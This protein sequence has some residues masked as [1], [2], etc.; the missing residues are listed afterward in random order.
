MSMVPK[1]INI[2]KL[3]LTVTTIR[4]DLCRL[5][6]LFLLLALQISMTAQQSPRAEASGSKTAPEKHADRQTG[7]TWAD[8]RISNGLVTG[9]GKYKFRLPIYIP[10]KVL[11]TEKANIASVD[12]THKK[13]IVCIFFSPTSDS[14]IT[15]WVA[16][17]P[18]NYPISRRVCNYISTQKLERSESVDSWSAA[19]VAEADH[20]GFSFWWY[21]TPGC[22][23]IEESLHSSKSSRTAAEMFPSWC[24]NNSPVSTA[25]RIIFLQA[26]VPWISR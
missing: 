26:A 6:F 17:L 15:S 20:C 3:N 22:S 8:L 5:L 18:I 14:R 25:S 9:V 13:L 21:S 1:S 4:P 16:N 24:A 19:S 12:T 11:L 2:G 23:A 10:S 7:N